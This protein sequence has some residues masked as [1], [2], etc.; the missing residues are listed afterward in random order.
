MCVCQALFWGFYIYSCDISLTETVSVIPPCWGWWKRHTEMLLNISHYLSRLDYCNR[1]LIDLPISTLLSSV[2]SK[3]QQTERSC[4]NLGQ[5]CYSSAQ[6][7]LVASHLTWGRTSIHPVF[8]KVRVTGLPLCSR[9]FSVFLLLPPASFTGLLGLSLLSHFRTI[10]P[11][12]FSSWMLFSPS[13][14]SMVPS[15][16]FFSQKSSS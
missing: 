3:S 13:I 9:P 6:N 10:M 14:I 2:R 5:T 4:W 8:N 12:T 15:F 7:L 11:A 1:F 16:T